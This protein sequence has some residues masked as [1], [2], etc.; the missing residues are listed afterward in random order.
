MRKGHVEKL[1]V[2]IIKNLHNWVDIRGSYAYVKVKCGDCGLKAMQDGGSLCYFVVEGEA[3]YAS[4][5]CEEI[6]IKTLIE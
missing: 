1:P 3:N 6:Q 4:L 2:H 5:T